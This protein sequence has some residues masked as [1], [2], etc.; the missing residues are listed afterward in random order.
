MLGGSFWIAL[1]RN[2]LGA[3]LIMG[4]F[5]LLDR[6]R[7]SRKKTVVYYCAF[8]VFAAVGFG[9]WYLFNFQMFVRFSG[10]MAIFVVGIFCM[11]MSAD[12]LYLSIY[13]MTLGFYLL[14]VTVFFGV[15][16]SRLWFGGSFWADILLRV[17]I[18]T[19]ML[20]FIIKRVR[21]RFQEGRDF[22]SAV[23]DL[24]SAVTLVVILMLAGVWA[25]WPDDHALSINR[26]VRIAVMLGMTGIIQWMTFRMYLYRGKEYCCRIEKELMELNELLLRRQ[27]SQMRTQGDQTHNTQQICANETVRNIL[28]TYKQ[29]AEEEKI[30]LRVRADIESD[31]TIREFDIAAILV[32]IFESAIYECCNSG[33]ET[34]QINL[35]ILQNKNKIVLLCQNTCAPEKNCSTSKRKAFS[36]KWNQKA[37]SIQ[38]LVRYYNGEVEFAIENCMRVSKILLDVSARGSLG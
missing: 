15:D 6:P 33:E 2:M 4:V 5:F 32:S 29:Y 21:P 27:L 26:V 1:I 18:E 17:V 23:M 12:L 36:E 16:G 19:V 14:S 38:K 24:P 22:L 3:V 7:F 8:G 37:E 30:S 28:S 13:K 31:L 34:R 35:V 11:V 25:Y 20:L 9:V 10:F